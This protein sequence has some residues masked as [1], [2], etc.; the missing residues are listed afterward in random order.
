MLVIGITG[1]NCAGKDSVARALE[2]RGFE[3]HSLSDV[4]RVE[5]RRRGETVTRPA[6]I[7]LGNE[8]RA[9]EGPATLARRVQAL[10]Q[11]DRVALVSV[12]NP[13][14]VACLCAI[15]RF[16]LWGVEAP[17]ETRFDREVGRNRE[18]VVR[19]LEG[20]Q[21][22]EARENT[23]DPN[24]QQLDATLA[25]ADHVIVNDGTLEDLDARVGALLE[26][27]EAHV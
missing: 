19:T 8:L 2:K 13:A 4:L 17:V 1:R 11:T 9:A 5:L 24:A 27:M 15:D 25:L 6:L 26:Q 21:D 20:F 10:M 16:V 23:K 7:A 18:S 14:E 3:S 12:R 22:L